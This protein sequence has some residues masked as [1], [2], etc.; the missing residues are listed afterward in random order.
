MTIWIPAL[1]GQGPRYRE[2]AD[3]IANATASGELVAGA[4]LPPQRRLADALGVTVGTVTRAYALAEQRGVVTARV[5][6]GTY[7]R[8]AGAPHPAFDHVRR[9]APDSGIVDLSLSLP[10]PTR[11]AR[12]RWRG[13]CSRSSTTPNC[14]GRPSIISRKR[15]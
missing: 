10:P 9:A 2:L 1:P 5:G 7:V 6:S 8:G 4:K 12:H 3:A 11:S 13:R 14:C 15:A